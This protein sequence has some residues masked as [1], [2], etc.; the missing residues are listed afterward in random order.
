MTKSVRITINDERGLRLCN[1]I[2]A[3]WPLTGWEIIE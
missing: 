1:A 2:K 3:G